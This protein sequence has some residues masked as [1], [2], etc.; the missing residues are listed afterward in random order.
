M[1]T[2]NISIE[3]ED[4]T[5]LNAVYD[6]I[7]MEPIQMKT[8]RGNLKITKESNELILEIT[9]TDLVAARAYMNSIMRLI[10]TSFDVASVLV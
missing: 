7:S 1:N 5:L 2:I 6:S 8:D 3:I 10:K 4:E 9:T